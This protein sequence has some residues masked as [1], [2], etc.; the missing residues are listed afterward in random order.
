M[1]KK[2]TTELNLVVDSTGNLNVTVKGNSN[3]LE[4]ALASMMVDDERFFNV[5]RSAIM[6][7]IAHQIAEHIEEKDEVEEQMEGVL[8][9]NVWS[10]VVA[11]A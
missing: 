7:V 9:N 5:V 11:E 4:A 10:K 2:I 8:P 6:N 3:E 1:K